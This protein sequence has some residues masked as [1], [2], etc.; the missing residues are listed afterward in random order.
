[1]GLHACVDALES[2]LQLALVKNDD[3]KKLGEQ[4][5]LREIRRRVKDESLYKP[6]ASCQR[7]VLPQ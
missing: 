4:E 3:L 5:A 7:V 6:W 2:Q 1:M